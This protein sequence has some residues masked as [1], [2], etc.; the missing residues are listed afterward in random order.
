MICIKVVPLFIASM[1]LFACH[2][3]SDQAPLPAGQVLAQVGGKDITTNELDAELTATRF[4]S[5]TDRKHARKEAL[6]GLI[7]RTILANIARAD[8][9]DQDP[10]YVLQQ[11]RANEILLV[12]NL[13]AA[14]AGKVAA[15]TDAEINAFISAHP[16]LFA[17]RKIYTLDQ[18]KFRAPDDLAGLKAYSP[19]KSMREI[20]Q[21][22]IEDRTPYDHANASLDVLTADVDVAAAIAKL[23]SDEVFLIPKNGVIYANHV[24]TGTVQP[25]E[26]PRAR[27]YATVALQNAAIEKATVAAI[28]DKIKVARATVRYQPD[29]APTAV[30]RS[31]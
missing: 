27:S 25:F 14:I 17:K 18:I 2:S 22:L 10:S 6:Q 1:S 11:H 26:G 4:A 28:G 8:K 20:E 15:P 3:G 9:L 5:E 24:L 29:Y 12:Q 21:K 19:L 31:R 23:P 16:D 13:Q 7:A 30:P